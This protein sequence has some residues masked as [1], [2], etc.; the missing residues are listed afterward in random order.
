MVSGSAA[1][2]EANFKRWKEITNFTLLERF[3]MTELGMALSNSC[4][5]PKKRY[6]GHV[7]T[8]MPGVTTKLMDLETGE[9]EG[10]TVPCTSGQPITCGQVIRLEH[11]LTG[12]NLHS[13]E[14]PSP[15]SG[16]N[17]VSAFG[18][19]GQGDTGDNW[20]IECINPKTSVAEPAGTEIT[21]ASVL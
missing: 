12:R 19:E 13:H 1:L 18:D 6:P 21:G 2:P 5:D 14:I 9:L 7:G 16:N 4:P 3:G 8:P 20:T 10:A 17:E 15:L 11:M